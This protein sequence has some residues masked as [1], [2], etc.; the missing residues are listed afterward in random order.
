[1]DPEIKK[2]RTLV[3]LV[4]WKHTDRHTCFIVMT[5][6]FYVEI[7]I[8]LIFLDKGVLGQKLKF[9]FLQPTPKKTP[10]VCFPES[11]YLLPQGFKV[12]GSILS[13]SSR[14]NTWVF[15]LLWWPL[16]EITFSCADGQRVG[17]GMGDEWRP[18]KAGKM[19][20]SVIVSTIKIEKIKNKT[21]KL[22]NK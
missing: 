5:L 1:M 12:T 9:L 2:V 16:Q 13:Q 11:I 17:G 6:I 14:L 7:K 10:N 22:K 19:G 8:V 18:V 3:C 20:T 21:M 4:T 15:F